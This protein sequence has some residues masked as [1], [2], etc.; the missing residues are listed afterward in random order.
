MA[1]TTPSLEPQGQVNGGLE[2]VPTSP[3]HRPHGDIPNTPLASA[4]IAFLLGILFALGVPTRLLM[5]EPTYW[6]CT[7]PFAFF[8]SSWATF[9]YLEFATTAGWNREKLSVDCES[10]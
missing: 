2:T 4:T 10:T 1:V 9:H 6:W 7:Y 3:A 8:T 5:R